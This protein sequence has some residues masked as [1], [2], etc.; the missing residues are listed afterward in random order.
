MRILGRI[1]WSLLP[2]WPQALLAYVSLVGNVAF[3]LAVPYLLKEVIDVGIAERRTDFLAIAGGLVVLF[4]VLRGVAGFGMSYL[5]EAVSQRAARDLRNR[6]YDRIQSL[7]FA[8]HDTAQTGQLM[9]RATA[10]VDQIRMFLNFGLLRSSQLLAMFFA[11]AVVL[12]LLNWQLALITFV[13]LPLVMGQATRVARRLRPLWL[14]VQQETGVLTTVLQENLAG[15]RV[16]KAFAR[17]E[18]ELDK[19]NAANRAVREKSLEANRLAAFNQPF[20]AFIVNSVTVVV[21]WYGGW[22]II[23]GGLTV[24]EIVAFLGYLTQLAMPVRILGFMV[25]LAARALSAGERVYEILD[26]RSAVANRPG[27]RP[28]G[29]IRGH[30]RFE[31]V[32]F[33]YGHASPVLRDVDVDARPGE[34]VALLGATG[35]GKTTIINL[36]PRFYDVTD[37]RITVDGA[38]VRDVTVESLRAHIGIVLQDV[39]LFS[40]TIRDNIA[41]GVPQAT[42]EQIQAAARTARIHEFIAGLPDGYQTWVGERGITLSGGQKQRIAIARTLLLDPRI[43]ILDDSTSSVDMETEYLIQQALAEVMRGRTTFVIAQRLRTIKHADQ[44]LVLENGAIVERGRHEDLLAREGYYR[45]IYDLQL[46]DQEELLARV[47]EVSGS[48]FKVQGPRLGEGRA[49]GGEAPR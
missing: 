2:Y 7:S 48:R 40:A 1:L 26:A 23:N 24:G 15:V 49:A 5:G 9:S 11:I 30:V 44:I 8:F 27:A 47:D 13:C 31:R 22:Q 16:V 43:L 12:F 20:M 37:G 3:T 45:E 38:D 29:E 36:I 18:H 6:L 33:R 19:F 41:Y 46:R 39:F 34:A 28:I 17:E 35:S 10:D 14:S 32:S 4:S 21:L 25:N 42:D